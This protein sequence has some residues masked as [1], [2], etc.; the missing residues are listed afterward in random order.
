MS[1]D[2]VRVRNKTGEERFIATLGEEGY[3]VHR[4]L[5]DDDFLELPKELAERLA[6]QPGWEL[7]NQ[8]DSKSRRAGTSAGKTTTAKQD[9]E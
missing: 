9:G 6:E 4:M 8:E 1:D 3:P 7:D 2:T 5:Q